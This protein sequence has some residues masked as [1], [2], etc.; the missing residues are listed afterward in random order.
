MSISISMESSNII[1][2][3][4]SQSDVSLLIRPDTGSKDY[5]WFYFKDSQPSTGL[6]R[7]YRIF[8]AAEASYPRA[9]V[10]YDVLA[11]YDEKAWFRIPTRFDGSH[12][13]W[14]HRA[15]S[16]EP[17]S[18]A[19]FVPYLSQRRSALL[20]EAARASHVSRRSLG[21]STQGRELD[22]LVFGDE[23]RQ[24]AKGVWVVS[25]QH[26]GETM[27]EF[28]TEGFIR[29]LLDTND[30]GTARILSDATIYVL[31]NMNPDG[32]AAGNLRANANGVDLNRAWHAPGDDA[33]EVKAVLA[34]IQQTGCDLFIDMH[35][36]ETRPFIWLVG[37]GV[38]ISD[39]VAA[40]VQQFEAVLSQRHPEVLPPPDEIVN[41]LMDAPG[42]SV[43]YMV[44]EY[45]CPGWI[46]EL[47]FR[48]TPEGDTMLEQ[49]CMSFGDS[50]V[51][52]LLAVM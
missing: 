26:A 6:T 38:P 20:E 7:T 49:G 34:A 16:G 18:F 12:L 3:S 32:S 11:S 52:A 40:K 42:M 15:D 8:N 33:P 46:V 24:D 1:V 45:G 28:A 51:D 2:E 5:Q 27:A 41:G 10:G 13:I 30:P 25:R 37:P 39:D 19:F 48:E 23:N 44:R 22:I 31:P 47:P 29:R 17:I 36:D 14:Q 9:W 50:C 4:E 35:G 43:N 21:Q